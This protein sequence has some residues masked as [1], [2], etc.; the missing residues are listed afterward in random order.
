MW[1]YLMLCFDNED[2]FLD[3]HCMGEVFEGFMGHLRKA[4]RRTNYQVRGY[5]SL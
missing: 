5:K 3:R 4:F 1:E 2:L